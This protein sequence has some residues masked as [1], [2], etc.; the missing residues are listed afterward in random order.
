M[1]K[2]KLNLNQS[3]NRQRDSLPLKLSLKSFWNLLTPYWTSKDSLV[4]WFIL[5]LIIALTAGSVYIATA[6]NSWYRSFWD[7][8][9]QYN[10]PEF[11]HELIIFCILATIHVLVTVY[12][13]FLKSRLAIRWRAWLTNKVLNEWLSKDTYYKMQLS[14]KNTDNPDQRI[15]DDLNLFVSATIVL[16]LGTCTDLALMITFGVVLWNLSGSVD[17]ELWGHSFSLPDGYMCY[18]AIAYA[19]LGTSVTFILGRPLVKLNFRQQRYEADFRFSLIRVRENSESI[20]MYKGQQEEGRFLNL[21]FFDVVKNYILLINCQK[22]LGFLTLGYAQLAVIF[23][24][25]IAAPLYFAKII[26]LGTIMQISSAFGR[27]QDALSTLVTNF[28]SWAE[29]KAVVDRL[30]LFFDGI[31]RTEDLKTLPIDHEHAP[32]KITNFEVRD[33][34]GRVLISNLNFSLDY[35]ESLLIQGHSGC[36]KSTLLKSLCGIWPYA[37]GKIE[38]KD[39]DKMLFLSQKPYLP[40]GSLAQCAFYPQSVGNK[41][42]LKSLL[43]VVGLE[44]LVDKIDLVDQW[45]HILSLG[46]M[47][48]IAI[49]RALLLKPK[50]LFLDEASSA[51]D[52][53]NEKLCYELLFENLASSI[54]ISVGHRVTL[55]N[56]HANILDMEKGIF[57]NAANSN[58]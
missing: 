34:S 26:T 16:I 9:E 45:S 8:L 3:S 5:I 19:V 20:A 31:Q 17:L 49:L 37:K 57:I 55:T 14:D 15:A 39:Q 21:K 53:K 6:I 22:R 27:V 44:H 52:V 11:K 43:K 33:P 40:Q 30:A 28:S 36:G 41:E 58:K 13:S 54:I 51:L 18:L 35:G 23:P 24:I 46:E 29:W 2:R 38:I 56:L 47:Q 10:L 7:A 42:E 4:S 25:L 32:F 12:N 1:F 50:V 48:R